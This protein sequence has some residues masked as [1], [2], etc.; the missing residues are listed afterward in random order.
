VAPKRVLLLAALAALAAVALLGLFGRASGTRRVPPSPPV[1]ARA[2]RLPEGTA[3]APDVAT[4]SVDEPEAA[5]PAAEPPP[6][7]PPRGILPPAAL[8]RDTAA[9]YRRRARHPRYSQPITD[10]QDPIVRDREVTRVHMRGP[11]GAEPTL[12]VF[13]QQAGFESPE[14][15]VLYAFLSVR[16]RRVAARDVRAAVLTEDLRTLGEIEYHDDGTNGDAQADDRLYTA[17]FTP[18]A[19]PGDPL[20]RSYLVKVIAH[21]GGDDERVAAT[22]FLYSRP[23]AHLTGSFRDTLVAGSLVLE[24]EVEVLGAGRF[25]LEGT[26]Y[27]A[28]GS[29]PLVWAQTAAELSPGRYWMSLPYYGLAL[30]ERG[31]DG[32]YLLRFVALSTTTEMPNAKNRL[33]ENAW[34]TQAFRAA[35]F[36]DQPF[37]DPALLDA[38]DRLERDGGGIGGLEAGG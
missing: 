5:A 22:S 26:L 8:A 27:S 36:T 2:P 14:P 13:P 11:R 4:P 33:L 7:T 18:G 32:P 1:P 29:E 30:R 20:A 28:D 3:P 35:A 23:Q 24:A 31:V 34:V 38:A 12:T 21:T 17:A 9:D 16:G 10:G 19:E 25:H 6:P 15:A 37:N